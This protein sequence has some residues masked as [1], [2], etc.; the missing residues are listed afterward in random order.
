MASSVFFRGSLFFLYFFTSFLHSSFFISIVTCSFFFCTSKRKRTKKENSPTAF[1]PL[2]M[3]L[4]FLKR[5]N[6]QATLAQTA[7]AFLRKTLPILL[8]LQKWGRNF[9]IFCCLFLAS[10]LRCLCLFTTSLRSFKRWLITTVVL[11]FLLLFLTSILM[12]LPLSRDNQALN[13][14]PKLK[15]LT[16]KNNHLT[17]KLQSLNT[18]LL[19]LQTNKLQSFNAKLLYPQNTKLQSLNAKHLS[20]LTNKLQSFKAKLLS[21]RP[22]KYNLLMLNFYPSW[23]TNSKP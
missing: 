13:T 4:V 6:S 14:S 12:P 3:A 5:E 7:R 11:Y 1:F 9:L 16:E 21:P 20:L 17:N 8:T 19:S 10:L 2:R 23:P 15:P 22:P 18:K